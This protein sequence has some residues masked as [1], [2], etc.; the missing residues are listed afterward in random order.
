MKIQDEK[1]LQQLSLFFDI[2]GWTASNWISRSPIFLSF[3][4]GDRQFKSF[5]TCRFEKDGCRK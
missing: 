2:E 1:E 3:K 5:F 4:K